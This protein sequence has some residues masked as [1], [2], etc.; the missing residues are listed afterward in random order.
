MFT[1]GCSVLVVCIILWRTAD[2]MRIVPIA[3]YVLRTILVPTQK[4]VISSPNLIQLLQFAE[5]YGCQYQRKRQEENRRSRKLAWAYCMHAS[6][7]WIIN[8]SLHMCA[9]KNVIRPS[10]LIKP[11]PP[12]STTDIARRCSRSCSWATRTSARRAWPSCSPRDGHWSRA[13]PLSGSIITP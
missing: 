12:R 2:I 13:R 7:H 4:V 10:P 9:H 11:S 6:G 3:S 1:R 5:H 8:D